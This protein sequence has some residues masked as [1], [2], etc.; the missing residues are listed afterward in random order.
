M[1]DAVTKKQL[2]QTI[3]T[4]KRINEKFLDTKIIPRMVIFMADGTN[5]SKHKQTVD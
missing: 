4:H 2:N 1:L 5:L 3:E